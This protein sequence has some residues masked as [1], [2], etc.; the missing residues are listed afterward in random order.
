M[1]LWY[2]FLICQLYWY[3][4]QNVPIS[5]ILGKFIASQTFQ[6]DSASVQ[7]FSYHS[8]FNKAN[9]LICP[10][11][12]FFIKYTHWSM[13][14]NCRKFSY[15]SHMINCQIREKSFLPNSWQMLP[16]DC[17][18]SFLGVATFSGVSGYS[19]RALFLIMY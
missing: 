3:F 2:F 4:F 7:C 9:F 19:C 14:K 11:W 1:F 12:Y 5:Q 15:R 6:R 13:L 10:Y 17:R 16:F 18:Q 8:M